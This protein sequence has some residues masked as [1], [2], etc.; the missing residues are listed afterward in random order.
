[1]K[2][3]HL[4]E[5]KRIKGEK[6]RIQTTLERE[7]VEFRERGEEVKRLKEEVRRSVFNSTTFNNSLS[8]EI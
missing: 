1:M 2:N 4:E 8:S 6:G 5:V 7:R 3:N